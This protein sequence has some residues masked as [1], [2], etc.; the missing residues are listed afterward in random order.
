MPR[1]A[2]RVVTGHTPEGKS[3]VWMDGTPPN[4]RDRGTGVD[5]IEIWNTAATPA[6]LTAEEPEPTDGPLVTPPR[7]TA[8]RSA[9]T[10]SIRAT[11]TS[12]RRAPTGGTR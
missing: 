4:I 7:R 10:T 2:R 11:S 9:S 3:V 8:P 12:S 6:P 1:Y 5:F